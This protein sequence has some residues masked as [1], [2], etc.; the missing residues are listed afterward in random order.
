MVECKLCTRRLTFGF[1]H[2]AAICSKSTSAQPRCWATCTCR[3]RHRLLCS[4]INDRLSASSI[5]ARIDPQVA[6]PMRWSF[7]PG[8][9]L[10]PLLT[11]TLTL[12]RALALPSPVVQRR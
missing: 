8:A 11:L 7:S 9:A 6:K 2:H 5:W 1:A 12:S 10:T 3:H 4:G